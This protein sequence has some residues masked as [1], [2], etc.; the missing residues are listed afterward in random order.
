M[1]G[2]GV[3]LRHV[4]LPGLAVDGGAETLSDGVRTVGHFG[5]EHDDDLGSP[6]GDALQSP[7]DAVRLRARDHAH[8]EGKLFH[9]Q[10]V[11]VR[12]STGTQPVELADFYNTTRGARKVIVVDL[13]FL[14]DSVHLVP[15]CWELRRHYPEA[16]IHTVSAPVGAEFLAL[17][18]CVDR[19]WALELDPRR[20]TLSDSL[21]LVHA[22]RRERFDAPG[23][24]V[25]ETE[26]GHR[27]SGLGHHGS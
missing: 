10:P 19:A 25:V 14:G 4:P 11:P 7:A 23:E 22:L 26:F 3:L 16:Q 6:A 21:R 1:G 13:G 18:P 2:G 27:R 15:A 8:R 20:R 17:A 5:I 24:R 12:L 9:R